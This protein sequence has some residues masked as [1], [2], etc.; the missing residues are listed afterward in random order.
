MSVSSV[1]VFFAEDRNKFAYRGKKPASEGDCEL[2]PAFAT[3]SMRTSAEVLSS[4]AKSENPF[5]SVKIRTLP[6]SSCVR[7]DSCEYDRVHTRQMI[8]EIKVDD[9]FFIRKV[10]HIVV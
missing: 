3:N 8:I 1:F 7:A 2:N 4:F 10:Y 6:D 5:A 9:T